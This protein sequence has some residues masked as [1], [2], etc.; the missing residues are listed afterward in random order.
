MKD[1]APELLEKIKNNFNEKFDSSKKIKSLYKKV[2]EGKADY[3]EA[4]KFA[5]ETGEYYHKHF[6]I[7]YH[8][9]NYQMGNCITI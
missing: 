8:P 3:E 1:I 4:Q 7:I 2:K 9:M 6:K 5:Q